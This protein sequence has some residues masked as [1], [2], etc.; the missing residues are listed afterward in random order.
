[1]PLAGPCAEHG[2]DEPRALAPKGFAG[3]GQVV[4]DGPQNTQKAQNT[5]KAGFNSFQTIVT[6]GHK[7]T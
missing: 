3:A 4:V 1:M 2:P 5:T 7:M 6:N